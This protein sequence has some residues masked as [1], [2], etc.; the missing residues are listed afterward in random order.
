VTLQ[1]VSREWRSS[2]AD[3]LTE[4]D[5]LL[6]LATPYI[7][8]DAAEWLVDTLS[9]RGRQPPSQTTIMTDISPGSA[10]SASLDVRALL[11]FAETLRG[12]TIFDVRRLHAKVYVAHDKRA[13]IASGNLTPSAFSTN[14]EYGVVVTDPEMVRKVY[15]D[16]QAYTRLGRQ[17]SRDE[18]ARLNEA[19]RDLVAQY[20]RS[21]EPLGA[22]IRREL[23]VEWDKIAAHFGAPSGV[24]EMGSARFKGPIVEVLASRGPLTTK[25]LCQAIQE[26]WPYLCDDTLMRVARDGSKKR[27]WRHDVH[28]AQETLQRAGVLRRDA[29]GL[30]HL[31]GR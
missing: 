14:H 7:K 28:T 6:L 12:V 23:A 18:L 4:A 16:M 5:Q 29:T 8:Y 13:I 20:Q 27:Q 17:I 26:S 30:W 24:H 11:L 25:D 21:A 1:F 3:L 19:S 15:S 2:L 31:Q 10:L 22:G 9:G